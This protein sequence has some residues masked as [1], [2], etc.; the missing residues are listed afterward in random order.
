MSD[1]AVSCSHC[2]VRWSCSDSDATTYA[3][4]RVTRKCESCHRLFDV[5]IP[6]NRTLGGLLFGTPHPPLV[7]E[8]EWA[9]LVQAVAS[10]N[11]EAF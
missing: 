1:L 7:S 11:E 9:A 3:G 4:R 5:D 8:R 2:G 10:G 6:P